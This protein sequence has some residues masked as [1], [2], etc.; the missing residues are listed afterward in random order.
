MTFRVIKTFH[1][2]TTEG[3]PMTPNDIE[4]LG[5]LPSQ[6]LDKFSDCF[7]RPAGRRLLRTFENGL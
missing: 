4:K 2:E 3:R 6:F 7:A 1:K 5:K